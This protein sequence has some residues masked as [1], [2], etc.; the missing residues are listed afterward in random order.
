[1][2]KVK[3][4]ILKITSE[5]GYNAKAK[6]KPVL[7]TCK[8]S[9]TVRVRRICRIATPLLQGRTVIDPTK[10]AKITCIYRIFVGYKVVVG[11]L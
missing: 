8:W 10:V 11:A 4:R 2:L 6:T 9:I 5:K 1:M 3:Y 7:T